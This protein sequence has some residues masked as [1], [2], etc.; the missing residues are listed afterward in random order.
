LM[1]RKEPGNIGP[2]QI[3]A[4]PTSSLQAP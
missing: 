1:A 3:D 4:E 2:I